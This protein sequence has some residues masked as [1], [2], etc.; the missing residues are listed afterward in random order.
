MPIK[1]CVDLS[2]ATEEEIEKYATE[3]RTNPALALFNNARKHNIAFTQL[4]DR[5][6]AINHYLQLS[7]KHELIEIEKDLITIGRKL[8]HEKKLSPNDLESLS[9]TTLNYLLEANGLKPRF[10]YKERL[11]P[12]IPEI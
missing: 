11:E 9:R 2:E 3:A 7:N 1:I 4:S 10:D 8:Q 12:L 6:T 5:E